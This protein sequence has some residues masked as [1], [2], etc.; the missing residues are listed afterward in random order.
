MRIEAINSLPVS[1]NIYFVDYAN[2]SLK[3]VKGY[4]Q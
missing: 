2:T 4:F 1:M 3:E